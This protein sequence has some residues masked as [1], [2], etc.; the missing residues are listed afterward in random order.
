VATATITEDLHTSVRLHARGWRTVYH[1]EALAYGIAPQSFSAFALQRLRWAQGTMQ[2]LRSRDNPLV[3]RGLTLAQRLNYLG[4]LLT[5]F[6]A[7]PKLMFFLTPPVILLT[8]V[9]PLRVG[10]QPFLGHWLPYITLGTLANVALG[11]GHFRYLRVER[12]NLLKT[13]T[14]LQALGT[15]LWPRPLRFRVTPK[16]ADT[17]IAGQERRQLRPQLLLLALIGLASGVALLNL[18]WGLTASYQHREL[19][20]MTLFWAVLDAGV[21]LLGVREVLRRQYARQGYRFPVQLAAAVHAASSTQRGRTENLSR[22][23]VSVRLPEG[24]SLSG[25]LTV[26]LTLPDGPLA[27][28][29]RVTRVQP[30]ADGG[31][32]LGLQFQEPAAAA[33][34]RLVQ[35][36]F[37]TLPGQQV[38][39]GAALPAAA[40]QAA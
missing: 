33:A 23:G 37:V 39:A 6:D 19:I 22:H 14:F 25:A 16:Q 3:I 21:L 40:A 1:D 12:Y 9:L 11:R 24:S 29:A 32:R 4:S 5:Y 8:G 10:V 30:L 34:S 27:L 26:V 15:L 31:C 20:L 2:L 35:Y 17:R 38:G 28:G 18:A 7:L 13:F 36:L